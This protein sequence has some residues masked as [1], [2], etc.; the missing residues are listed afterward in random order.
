[1]YT[2]RNFNDETDYQ[3]MREL[4]I[5]T[6]PLQSPPINCLLGEIDWWRAILSDT[7]V[8]KK[9]ILYFDQ[10]NALVAF[11]W[12]KDN[13]MEWMIHPKNR[14]LERQIIADLEKAN[15]HSSLLF[16]SYENDAFRVSL[17]KEFGYQ[18][19]EDEFLSCH[20]I[21][22]KNEI[23]TKSCPQG[24]VVRSFAGESEIESRVEAHKSA[25]HPSKMTL[26]KQRNVMR[27]STYRSDLEIV[28]VAPDNSI[29][30][31]TIIWYDEANRV[32][33]FEPVACH[34]SHQRRGLASAVMAEGLR[35]LRSLGAQKAYV[36]SH[37]DDSAGAHIYR[38]LGFQIIGRL[39]QWKK[40]F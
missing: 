5:Q 1:M 39:F 23:P 7:G 18:R 10:A 32:G 16:F 28:C 11:I 40:E 27:S 33:I 15:S 19:V 6:Y 24:Y 34:V 25:F 9:I 13:Q 36:M 30:A 31:C 29:A 22:L 20:T 21:E 35:R 37:R 3:K 12:P 17:L 2:C 26:E 14:E 4:L 8:L 38:S